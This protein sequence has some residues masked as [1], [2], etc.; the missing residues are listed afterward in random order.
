VISFFRKVCLR[1]GVIRVLLLSVVLLSLEVRA[2]DELPFWKKKPELQKK[3]REGREIIVSVRH[4]DLANHQIHFA[5]AGAG[6]VSRPK[7]FCF[8]LSQQYEKLKLVSDHFKTVIFDEKVNQLYLVTEALGYEARMTMKVSP[9]IGEPASELRWEVIEG[10]FKGMKGVIGFEK[11]DL[12]HTE[13]SLVSNYES[14]HLPLPKI[15]MGFALEV[16]TQKVAEKMRTF[17]ESQPY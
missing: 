7:E 2:V 1:S 15:L 12:A 9:I 3:I 13:M 11:I 16:I 10:A 17:I 8:K 5:M 4:E 6:V 14:D